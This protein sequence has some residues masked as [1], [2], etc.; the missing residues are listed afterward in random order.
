MKKTLFIVLSLSTGVTAQIRERND[1]ELAPFIGVNSSNYYGDITYVGDSNKALY[2]PTFGVTADFYL[3]SRWSVRT[4][5]EYQTLGSAV[6]THDFVDNPQNNNYYRY[7]YEREKLHYVAV[8]IHANIH[9]GKSRSWHV[10]FGPT[11]SFLTAAKFGD[12]K[13]QTKNLR[14][15]HIGF[16]LGFGYRFTINEHFSLGIEHQEYISFSNNLN[17]FNSYGF[18]GNIAGSFSIKAI[19]NIPSTTKDE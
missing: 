6:Y 2:T 14:K 7:F 1:V 16:G 15:E 5:L 19:F 17:S 4:G 3:N 18:V 10:N 8:P 11:L 12:E 13:V 9:I